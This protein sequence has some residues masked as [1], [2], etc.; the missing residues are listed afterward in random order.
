MVYK[1]YYKTLQVKKNATQKEIKKA[2]RKLAAKYHPDKNPGDKEAEEKFKEINEAHEVLSDPEKR[3]QYDQIDADHVRFQQSSGPGNRQYSFS[4]N[5]F[6]GFDSSDFGNYSSFFEQ[7]FGGQ[8]D[9]RNSFNARRRT[10]GFQEKPQTVEA[11]LQVSFNDA[12]FGKRTTFIFEGEKLRINLK[13]GTY[14]GLSLKLKN[15]GLAQRGFAKRG[16]LIIH[17]KVQD[18]PIF[19]KKDLDLII[20]KKIDIYTAL[21]GG[22]IHVPTPD[23][24]VKLK[25]PAGTDYGAKLRIKGKGFPA[26]G[27]KNSRGNLIVVVKFKTPKVTRPEGQKLVL[28]LKELNRS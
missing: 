3:K 7:F 19:K 16:D 18:H 8:T 6:S 12:F 11:N 22:E 9:F 14:D 23:G 27:N 15:K 5:D 28:N 2:F 21:I 20:E 25:I 17:I 24:E 4:G 13:P 26:Y 10:S 1:D